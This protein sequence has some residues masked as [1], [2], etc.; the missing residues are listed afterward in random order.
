MLPS[1]NWPKR[2]MPAVTR[3]QSFASQ[4]W[5]SAMPTESSSPTVEPM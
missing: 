1:T 4:N 2:K 5:K 3:I